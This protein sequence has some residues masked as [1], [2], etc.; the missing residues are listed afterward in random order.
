MSIPLNAEVF[1]NFHFSNW[2]LRIW[3]V[4]FLTEDGHSECRR[5]D[6]EGTTGSLY[7]MD[8]YYNTYPRFR[9]A[10]SPSRR[11]Q[12]GPFVAMALKNKI[13]S[14]NHFRHAPM[15]FLLSSKIHYFSLCLIKWFPP[16]AFL[17]FI[18]SLPFQ[19]L[20]PFS[21]V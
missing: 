6:S 12:P 15:Y 13:I 2:T 5:C 7:K 4:T 20:L 14:I 3:T 16:C 21:N 19:S 1:K 11:I 9:T 18:F 10:Y 17:N 8:H